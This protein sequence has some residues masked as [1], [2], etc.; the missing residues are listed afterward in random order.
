MARNT[1]S[2]VNDDDNTVKRNEYTAFG[3]IVIVLFPV[4]ASGLFGLYG[5]CVWLYN[6]FGG[7]PGHN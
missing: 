4:L 5:L 6:T 3:F 2:E 7:M 1:S